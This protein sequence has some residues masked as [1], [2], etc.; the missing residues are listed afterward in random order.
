MKVS[1]VIPVFNTEEY[2]DEC[3]RSVAVQD[4]PDLEILLINDG[5]GDRSGE[6]CRKWEA[7]DPRV[8]YI[9]QENQG[10]G[11]ARNLGI[12]IARGEYIL[13]VDSDDYI[14]PDL[15]SLAYDCISRA[16]ADICVFA[17]NGVGDRIY[18]ESLEFKLRKTCSLQ[19]NRELLGRQMPILWDKL[20]AADLLKNAGFAMSSRICEDLVYNARLYRKARGICFLDRP[21]YN[22]RYIRKGNLS[23]N[24]ERYWEVQESIGEL[25]RIYQEEGYSEEYWV[26][27]YQISFFMFKDILYR[28][29][30]RQEYD[31]PPEVR[32]GYPALFRSYKTC[33]AQWFSHHLA[34]EA[35]EKG[36]FLIG[37]YSLRKE[38]QAFLL[39]E[40][41]LR[42]HYVSGSLVSLM[43]DPVEESWGISWDGGKCGNAYRRNCVEQEFRKDFLRQAV[44]GDVDYVA[45]DLLG[46]VT[47]LVN[48]REGCCISESEFLR[49]AW[50]EGL[51]GCERIPFL[52]PARRA[53]FEKYARLFA[54]KVQKAGVS[55]IVVKNFL[56]EKHGGC[57]DEFLEYDNVEWI[58]AANQELEWCYG[59]LLE[60]IP[61]ALAADASE[62]SELVFTHDDF[63][64]GREPVYY[65]RSY[66]QRMAV[67]AGVEIRA[68]LET[69]LAGRLEA[70]LDQF[71]RV[72]FIPEDEPEKEK[73]L[74]GFFAAGAVG[75]TGLRVLVLCSEEKQFQTED[76]V[77]YR[78]IT[79]GEGWLLG[80]LYHM[81]EFSDRFRLA[82][83]AE[84][85]GGLF[86]LVETGLLE[87]EEAWEAL[88]R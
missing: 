42:G 9:E 13:F 39:D 35:Q 84:N 24:Y 54:E 8:R 58:R 31:V 86:R 32:A 75:K 81:Y 36:Y 66:Y 59:Y 82:S 78:Q 19:E 71:D 11:A 23:T 12:R 74:E 50:V 76:R 63:P 2:L 83:R 47:D 73:L 80:T 37:S 55:V 49:E 51:E 43:S 72:I 64:F 68:G 62:F 61:E 46:E 77:E 27:L 16:R 52:S 67:Q 53:L 44:P 4:C 20:Y 28:I 87:E 14:E 22:Y 85:R 65:N 38:F 15:V 57:Y 34:I 33:L 79:E 17:H 6:I 70:A 26:Q 41:F 5:S 3:I 40:D 56:C 88:L 18:K 25:N 48:I 30:M 60:C 21:L 10:Q 7:Q 69:D 45:V 29:K 1:V